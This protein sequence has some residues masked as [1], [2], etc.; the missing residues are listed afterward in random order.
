MNSAEDM[1]DLFKGKQTESSQFDRMYYTEIKQDI[2]NSHTKTDALPI[3]GSQKMYCIAFH[4]DGTVLTSRDICDCDEC[5]ADNVNNCE[6]EEFE[7]DSIMD[8]ADD[9]HI[10]IYTD[11]EA[12]SDDESNSE[13]DGY[14]N[15]LDVVIPGQ[16]VALR[17]QTHVYESFPRLN[18]KHLTRTNI[19]FFLVRDI[20]CVSTLQ[21]PR[22]QKCTFSTK[23]FLRM[24]LSF[25]V[26]SC[27]LL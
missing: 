21:R 6:Y 22:K 18:R 5:F 15:I 10:E 9:D 14:L 4:P 20:W 27:A 13:D 3:K 16:V 23:N 19:T 11:D 25:Q 7:D 24:Y 26:K 2:Y 8:E 1:V 17:T 12:D